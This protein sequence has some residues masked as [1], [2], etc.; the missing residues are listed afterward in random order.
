MRLQTNPSLRATNSTADAVLKSGLTCLKKLCS[1]VDQQFEKA[2]EKF[3]EEEDGET[4]DGDEPEEE[5][6]DVSDGA[7]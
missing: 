7:S 4:G 3:D 1:V 2:C 6:D 5:D